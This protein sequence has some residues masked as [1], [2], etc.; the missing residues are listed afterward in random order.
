[1]ATLAAWV[2]IL[3]FDLMM[4]LCICNEGALVGISHWAPLPCCVLTLIFGPLG[5]LTFLALHWWLAG[6]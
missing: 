3:A 1:L 2:H 6:T 5:L 4:G